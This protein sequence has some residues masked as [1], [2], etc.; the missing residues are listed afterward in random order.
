AKAADPTDLQERT[1]IILRKKGRSEEKTVMMVP[2]RAQSATIFSDGDLLKISIEPP[3]ASYIYLINREQYRDG[4]YSEPYLVFPTSADVG[5]ND[6]AFPGRLIFLPSGNDDD[7]F[8]LARLN[9]DG[10][11]KMAEAFTIILSERRLEV[12][13]PLVDDSPRRL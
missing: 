12:L 6:Q 7:K 1:R 3:F 5:R 4:S 13:P 11:E 9:P 8:E 10:V 2:A